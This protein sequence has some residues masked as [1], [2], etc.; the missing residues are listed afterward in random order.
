M[1]LVDRELRRTAG[2]AGCVDS[3]SKHNVVA[4][5]PH[6]PDH[7][8]DRLRQLSNCAVGLQSDGM[9]KVRPAEQGWQRL[10][11][12]GA[13]ICQIISAGVKSP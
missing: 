6:R 10:T 12:F 7:I 9:S 5:S 13:N 1:S 3:L 11:D 8:A 2:F 4:K